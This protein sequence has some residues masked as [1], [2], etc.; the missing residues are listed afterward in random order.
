VPGPQGFGGTQGSPGTD[1]FQ[2]TSG[3]SG[4]DGPQGNNGA[5]GFFG[6]QGTASLVPG[7]VGAP[8][9]DG[10]Q[11]WM[12]PQG[13]Q[14]L[15]GLAG[16][17]GPQGLQGPVN[18]PLQLFAGV[19]G[20]QGFQGPQGTYIDTTTALLYSIGAATNPSA[21]L[22]S[23]LLQTTLGNP[24]GAILGPIVLGDTTF[25]IVEKLIGNIGNQGVDNFTLAGFQAVAPAPVTNTDTVLLAIEHLASLLN[26][27]IVTAYPLTG[28]QGND[29]PQGPVVASDSLLDGLTRLLNNIGND[30]LTS[31]V[32]N[33]LVLNSPGAVNVSGDSMTVILQKLI[34]NLQNT[35]VVQNTL[36]GYQ[37]APVAFP[38]TALTSILIAIKSLASLAP[39]TSMQAPYSG[40]FYANAEV[41]SFPDNTTW[42][43]FP[44]AGWTDLSDGKSV[45]ITN[46]NDPNVYWN[47]G[48]AASDIVFSVAVSG[49]FEVDQGILLTVYQDGV[50][51]QIN[52]TEEPPAAMGAIGNFASLSFQTQVKLL[53]GS[54]SLVLTPQSLLP[55][56]TTSP[57]PRQINVQAIQIDIIQTS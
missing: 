4:A 44:A 1:G 45:F 39:T 24:N 53:A 40:S 19:G 23:G 29:G 20:P 18:V 10:V 52:G 22:T 36:V 16:L 46:P 3:L 9:L 33:N 26:N 51:V 34:G 7:A 5:Q 31:Y 50:P 2:G 56:N 42:Q 54:S 57:P 6:P 47:G 55:W 8:G 17:L 43:A 41:L 27:D 30:A 12:G 37:T 48:V 25:T 13:S 38:I 15:M 28:F 11:G 49:S 32:F 35:T 21:S 14:G